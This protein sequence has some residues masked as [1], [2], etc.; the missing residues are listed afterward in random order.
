MADF[1]DDFSIRSHDFP[2]FWIDRDLLYLE[3]LESQNHRKIRQ[4]QSFEKIVLGSFFIMLE[5][6]ALRFIA[7]NSHSVRFGENQTWKIHDFLELSRFTGEAFISPPE[8]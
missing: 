3:H 8:H 7:P 1:F 2:W 5:V 6:L 4:N